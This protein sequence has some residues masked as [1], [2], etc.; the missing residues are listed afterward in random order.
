MAPTDAPGSFRYQVGGID[1]TVV[2]DG[3]RTFPLPDTFVMNA[4]RDAVNDALQTAGMERD[5][6]TIV[7][8]PIVIRTAGQFIA[9][10]TGN[11]Q[12]A[13]EQSKGTLGRFHANLAQAG[14]AAEHVTTVV[15]THFHGDHING[16]LTPDGSPAFANADIRVPQGEWDFWLDDANMSRAAAGSTVEAN[17]KNV[18]RVFGPLR[19]R[20]TRY[21]AGATVTPGLTAL[22]TPGHTPGH[23]SLVIGSGPDRVIAQGDVTNHP[24][25]F[26]R[27]PGWHASFDMDGALAEA[28][29]RKLYD[30]A[31]AEKLRIQG[32]HYPFPSLAFVEKDGAGYRLIPAQ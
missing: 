11:G 6:M 25:L 1:V 27:N 18:R 22:A 16:L 4:S 24:A 32:F 29:R 2:A 7:F 8:N 30:M 23:T 12:A 26:V 5:Q 31:A 15:I 28:T 9:I 13:F 10:D 19:D 20:V 21:K 14:I 17:F 3:F